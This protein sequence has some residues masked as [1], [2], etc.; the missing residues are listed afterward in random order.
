MEITNTELTVTGE[1]RPACLR[2]E[3]SS[4]APEKLDMVTTID[5][6]EEGGFRFGLNIHTHITG[7]FGR[8]RERWI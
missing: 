4:Y 1:V 8:D 2:S 3:L 5:Y 6:N 7:R